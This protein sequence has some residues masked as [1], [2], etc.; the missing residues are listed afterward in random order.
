[1]ETT[2]VIMAVGVL[3]KYNYWLLSKD[4][5]LKDKVPFTLDAFFNIYKTIFDSS[6][7]FFLKCILPTCLEVDM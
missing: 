6:T 1:V 7:H 2:V 4:C 5:I 3:E